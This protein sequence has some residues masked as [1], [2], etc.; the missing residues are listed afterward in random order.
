MEREDVATSPLNNKLQG[1]TGGSVHLTRIGAVVLAI[2]A[3]LIV[4]VVARPLFD[5]NLLATAMGS[6]DPDKIV[7]QNTI[8]AFST[9]GIGALIVVYLIDRFSSNPA[10]LWLIVSVAAL[11]LSFIPIFASSENTAT[12]I[13]FSIMHLVSGA[14]IIP[15]FLDTLRK[16]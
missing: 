2:V 13:T 16:K 4:W 12:T 9:W 3:S 1:L 8:Y 7:W 6:D 14:I 10:R 11:V 5:A 15:A